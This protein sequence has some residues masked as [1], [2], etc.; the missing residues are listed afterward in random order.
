MVRKSKRVNGI[1]PFVIEIGRLRCLAM[2]C[3]IV[4]GCVKLMHDVVDHVFSKKW[5]STSGGGSED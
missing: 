2:M 3:D 1:F 4:V 5:T